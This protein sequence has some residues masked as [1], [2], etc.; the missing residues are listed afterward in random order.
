MSNSGRSLFKMY[1]KAGTTILV[2]RLQHIF[3]PI[4]TQDD[5]ALHNDI[6]A[7]VLLII[8]DK[9]RTFMS[10]LVDLILYKKIPK[11]KRFL[12]HV[13]TLILEIGHNKGE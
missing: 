9:E 8:E 12:F 7:E 2:H 3:H 6:L 10:D 11:Q 4:K 5:I 13:A 1:D